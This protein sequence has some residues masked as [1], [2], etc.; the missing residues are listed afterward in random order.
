LFHNFNSNKHCTSSAEKKNN[1]VITFKRSNTTTKKNS[2]SNNNQSSKVIDNEEKEDKNKIN[3]NRNFLKK[4]ILGGLKLPTRL[5]SQLS[6]GTASTYLSYSCSSDSTSS[7]KQIN[8]KK[9]NF[10]FYEE[11][12]GLLGVEKNLNSYDFSLSTSLSNS[13]S[14]N[15][16]RSTDTSIDQLKPI[17]KIAR[18]NSRNSESTT[19]TN[20]GKLNFI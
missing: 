20:S 11:R 15:S 3:K 10:N 17:S 2:I 19:K 18:I 8:K 9:S 6:T 13:N 4:I 5:D 7:P 1:H 16:S 12:Q 14:N